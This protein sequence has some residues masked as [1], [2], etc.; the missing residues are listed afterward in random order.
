MRMRE[1]FFGTSSRH[2]SLT[3]THG[4][5]EGDPAWWSVQG[6]IERFSF[7]SSS[8]SAFRRRS[9]RVLFIYPS[10]A[11]IA[12]RLV[13]VLQAWV[14]KLICCSSFSLLVLLLDSRETSRRR[15]ITTLVQIIFLFSWKRN[16]G[17]LTAHLSSLLLDKK[18]FHFFSETIL[19]ED[20]VKEGGGGGRTGCWM[21]RLG[22]MMRRRK[23]KTRCVFSFSRQSSS[24][25][26]LLLHLETSIWS[27]CY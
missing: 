26:Y 2:D 13:L 27:S 22:E 3:H 4:R 1:L 6:L 18:L 7:C 5:S 10:S 19:S 9:S 8:S 12:P 17:S 24:C 15:M 11:D 20:D 21:R 23:R 14:P 25:F 16:V